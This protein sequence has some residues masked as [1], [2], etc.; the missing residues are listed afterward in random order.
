MN[1]SLI[2]LGV[3]EDNLDLLSVISKIINSDNRFRL[4]IAIILDLSINKENAFLLISQIKSTFSKLF[5]IVYTGYYEKEII[6]LSKKAGANM[7]FDKG[8]DIKVILDEISKQYVS[9]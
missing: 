7:I 2:N 3:Y 6:N 8:T 1:Q 9:R 5:L 4:L